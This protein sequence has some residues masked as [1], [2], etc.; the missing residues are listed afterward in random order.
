MS[1]THLI[2]ANVGLHNDQEKPLIIRQRLGPR[3]RG[4]EKNRD[5]ISTHRALAARYWCGR[6]R[7]GRRR[8]PRRFRRRGSCLVALV[9]V[10]RLKIGGESPGRTRTGCV[11]LLQKPEER[12]IETA[13]GKSACAV[14]TSA[15]TAREQLGGRF[16]L[17]EVLGMSHADQHNNCNRN[18]ETAS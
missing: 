7:R 18:E 5:S 2:P 10:D 17:I 1:L 8:A 13:F 6:S 11:V 14:M 9:A 4:D 15:A 12:E 3:V 16:A